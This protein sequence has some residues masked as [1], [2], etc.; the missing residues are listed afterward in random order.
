ME[1]VRVPGQ[2]IKKTGAGGGNRTRV[3]SLEDWNSTIELRPQNSGK[4]YRR[5]L[6]CQLSSVYLPPR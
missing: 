2:Q 3:A 5:R 6:R 1:V 4:V